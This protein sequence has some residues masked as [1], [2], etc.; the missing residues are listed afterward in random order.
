[1]IMVACLLS[2]ACQ[3]D[4]VVPL[5]KE[6]KMIQVPLNLEAE[7]VCFSGDTK[8]LTPYIPDYE[9]LIYDIWVLQYSS[10]GVLLSS[11]VKQYRASEEGRMKISDLDISLIESEEDCTVCL[12]V[13]M[14]SDPLNDMPWPDNLE[15]YKRVMVPVEMNSAEGGGLKMPMNGFYH[16][17]VPPVDVD[18]IEGEGSSEYNGGLNVTL[19]RMMCRINIILN[20]A[21]TTEGYTEITRLDVRMENM[22]DKA[23]IFP[24]VEYVMPDRSILGSE[25]DTVTKSINP[26]ESQNFYYYIAPNLYLY[27]EGGTDF[28]T[29]FHVNASITNLGERSGTMILGNNGP[30][31]PVRDYRLYPNNNYTFTI[32]LT[33]KQ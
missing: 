5:E 15:T 31:T 13:N 18:Y 9:N 6:G 2:L 8:A 10:R 27:E 17:P 12:L 3:K 29:K 33:N 20:N 22:P 24:T 26:G 25:S 32:N 1:M 16:G 30:D 4:D 28:R 11:T 21:L 23:H 14:G 19:G 7:S